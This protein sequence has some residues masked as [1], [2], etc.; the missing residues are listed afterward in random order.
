MFAC[1]M[2]YSLVPSR[3]AVFDQETRYDIVVKAI[4][5]NVQGAGKQAGK[6]ANGQ[7]SSFERP[8]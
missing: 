8:P 5:C 1:P 7:V 4:A 6:Q 2:Y 3:V